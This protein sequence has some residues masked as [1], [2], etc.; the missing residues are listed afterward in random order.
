[1]EENDQEGLRSCESFFYQPIKNKFA[2]NNLLENDLK[3]AAV[4]ANYSQAGA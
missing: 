2:S 1:M 3:Q 4:T